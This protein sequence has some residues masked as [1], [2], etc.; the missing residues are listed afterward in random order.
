MKVKE[1]GIKITAVL[2]IAALLVGVGIGWLIAPK[3][4]P[5]PTVTFLST[6]LR[7][8]PETEWVIKTLLPPFEK[9][10]DA[11]VRFV[12]EEYAIFEDR[13]I[14][15]VEAGKVKVSVAGGLHGDFSIA[16]AKGILTDLRGKPTLPGRTFI[17]AL[18]KLSFE[19]EKQWYIPWMQATYM[20]VANKK[21]L[22]Y[23]PEGVN[24]WALTYDDMFEWAKKMYEATGEKKL[25]LPAGPKGLFGRM[26][27]GYLYP[28]FTGKQVANFNTPEAV[29]MWEYLKRLWAYVHPS[30]LI[31]E[32][33]HGPLLAEEVWVAWDHTARFLP[34][35]KEKPGDFVALPSPAGP[36]G[37]G[38]IS[39]IAGLAIPRGA[40]NED[41]AWKFIE[42]LTRPDTQ[43]KIL[44]GVG[45]F[46]VV[47]EAVGAIPTGPLKTVAE[48]VTKQAGAPDAIVAILP[49]G[50]GGRVGEF[51]PIYIDSFH[52][53]VIDGV[54]IV[55]VLSAQW[56]KLDA[57][58]KETGAPYPPPG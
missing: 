54:P 28:S 14:A 11:V 24:M 48:G 18:W 46:P 37:R 17:P 8:P 51:V 53:I 19:A 5:V 22:D 42:Y 40:P 15:E 26:L 30:S 7:P 41:L 20:L 9:E 4:P 3:P 2:V 10:F 13:L 44:E 31:Y 21:A 12:P 33:M 47:E 34:A 56:A 43:V 6:Q 27:H 35:I 23:L 36:K 25:G 58:Y 57:L 32:H 50:L 49:I 29:A 55:E 1:V 16:I 52:A 38:F 45:F 39:V